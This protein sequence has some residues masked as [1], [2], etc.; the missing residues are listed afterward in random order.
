[1]LTGRCLGLTKRRVLIGGDAGTGPHSRV[2]GRELPWFRAG[3]CTRVSPQVSARVAGRDLVQAWLSPGPQRG[4]SG[5]EPSS[6]SFQSV[7]L[8]KR[9]RFCPHRFLY[10]QV[11]TARGHRLLLD[12][13]GSSP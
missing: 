4:S 9:L 7:A 8:Q 10:V 11:T 3:A 6:P 5:S 13:P 2:R 1:M 12:R